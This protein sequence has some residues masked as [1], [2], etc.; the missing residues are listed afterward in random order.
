MVMLIDLFFVQIGYLDIV[1]LLCELELVTAKASSD[2]NKRKELRERKSL[3]TRLVEGRTSSLKEKGGG[4][5]L[6]YS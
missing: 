6:P 5:D 3:L 4:K 2:T 1:L